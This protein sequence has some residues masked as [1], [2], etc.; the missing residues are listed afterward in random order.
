MRLLLNLLCLYQLSQVRHSFSYRVLLKSTKSTTSIHSQISNT[1]SYQKDKLL[2]IAKAALLSQIGIILSPKRA[3]A[4]SETV[5][6]ECSESITVLRKGSNEA[7][8]IGTAHISEESAKLVQR[9]IRTLSPSTVMIELD[10]KRIG[11]FSNATTLKEAGFSVPSFATVQIITPQTRPQP[12]IIK[13]LLNNIKLIFGSAVQSLSGA[14]LGQILSQFY[15]SVEKL[16]F[17]TGTIIYSSYTSIC[18]L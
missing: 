7:V 17:N 5:F 15:K 2:K 10:P 14:V 18:R 9:T 11:R 1:N 12:N 8:V 16:G 6:P 4:I 3:V 13:S